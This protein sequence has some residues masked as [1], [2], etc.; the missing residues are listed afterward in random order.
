MGGEKSRL[1]SI[2][3]NGAG[4]FHIVDSCV[5]VGYSQP[6]LGTEK[7]MRDQAEPLSRT[8]VENYRITAFVTLIGMLLLLFGNNAWTQNR[9]IFGADFGASLN[10]AGL[11]VLI[12]CITQ[13]YTDFRVRSA[14]YKDIFDHIV[15]N[16][17][18]RESGIIKFFP[19]SKQCFVSNMIDRARKIDVGV[20]YSARF[21][22]DN[23]SKILTKKAELKIR[24]FCSDLSDREIKNI[25]CKNIGKSAEEVEFE[26]E[27]LMKS[28]EDL[29][30]SGVSIEIIKQPAMP[31][32]S[33]YSFDDDNYFLTFSTFA[34]RRAEVPLV[35]VDKSSC[36]ADLIRK[37]LAHI[38]DT[39]NKV[40]V[41]D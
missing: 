23:H 15:A 24:L 37:D 28:V 21:F 12:A 33:F 34:S 38:C 17:S 20:T 6:S 39:A 11:A 4:A 41:C 10:N 13:F 5:N 1:Q 30:Q 32:Y 16:D 14:F 19:D 22:K 35:Q 25:I 27:D 7:C 8:I 31:H 2:E 29:R 18:I 9:Q 40:G 3:R 26:Y 36:I